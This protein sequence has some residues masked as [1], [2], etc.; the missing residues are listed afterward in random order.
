M[1]KVKLN[2]IGHARSGDKGNTV[3]IGVFANDEKWYPY[4]LEQMTEER[5]KEFFEGLEL[6]EVVRYEVPNIHGINVV[7]TNELDDEVSSSMRE[8]NLAK[9]VQS[10]II[11]YDRDEDRLS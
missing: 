3:N 6:G 11:G 2:E 5:V 7:C 10:N 8:D 9:Y 4:L 1:S